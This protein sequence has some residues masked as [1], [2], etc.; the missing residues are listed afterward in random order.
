MNPTDMIAYAIQPDKRCDLL[1]ANDR[2]SHDRDQDEYRVGLGR[3][4]IVLYPVS[5]IGMMV[6][7]GPT[8]SET[9][10]GRVPAAS[11]LDDREH[12]VCVE[13]LSP[14]CQKYVNCTPRRVA[15]LPLSRCMGPSSSG[16]RSQPQTVARGL[17]P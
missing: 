16:G 7:G 12:R 8:E 11:E 10:R 6:G 4:D 5:A 1:L 2:G 17:V 14:H 13:P 3:F 15:F 9:I